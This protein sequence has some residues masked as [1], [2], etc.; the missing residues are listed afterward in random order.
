[1]YQNAI[2]IS[3]HPHHAIHPCKLRDCSLLPWHPH[4]AICLLRWWVSQ[5][6]RAP[7]WREN[8]FWSCDLGRTGRERETEW[9]NSR[10]A[11][12]EPSRTLELSMRDRDE[13]MSR[14]NR[15]GFNQ[16]FRTEAQVLSA[17]WGRMICLWNSEQKISILLENS[18][19]LNQQA[20]RIVNGWTEIRGKLTEFIVN[21]RLMTEMSE[22][23]G[24]YTTRNQ[25]LLRLSSLLQTIEGFWW[26]E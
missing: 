26:M 13:E 21:R 4:Y 23:Q 15:K 5:W 10:E 8:A 2:K 7:A 20:T 9:R 17:F 6:E 18:L 19:I 25:E 1:M 14:Q 22:Q 24:N 12:A 3:W 11:E 16:I